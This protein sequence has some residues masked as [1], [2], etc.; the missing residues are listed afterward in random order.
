MR[1]LFDNPQASVIVT[2]IINMIKDMKTKSLVEGVETEEQYNFLKDIGTDMAQGF[3]F[4]KPV[5]IE[6]LEIPEK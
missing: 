6:E 4:N 2:S 5:P 3:L 1:K